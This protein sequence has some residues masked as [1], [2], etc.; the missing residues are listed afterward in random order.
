[1]LILIVA[2][3]AWIVNRGRVVKNINDQAAQEAQAAE[4]EQAKAE[5]EAAAAKEA[6]EAAIASHVF[7]RSGSSDIEEHSFKAYDAAIEAGARAVK[8]V[9]HAYDQCSD[10][11][12]ENGLSRTQRLSLDIEVLG[13][14]NVIRC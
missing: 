12:S 7:A 5:E 14:K 10:T 3:S 2:A 13:L 1:M 4:E 6:E 9:V 11:C 8:A